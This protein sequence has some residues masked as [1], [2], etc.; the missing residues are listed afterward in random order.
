MRHIKE[1]ITNENLGALL[2]TMRYNTGRTILDA[3][4]E[5]DCASTSVHKWEHNLTSPQ[6]SSVLRLCDV[7]GA[8]LYL[9]FDTSTKEEK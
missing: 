6:V 4:Y 8:K 2:A 1:E 9:E 3:A 7:Y 5:G